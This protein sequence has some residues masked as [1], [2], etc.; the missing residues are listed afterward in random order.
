VLSHGHY[1]HTGGLNQVLPQT[2]QARIFAHPAALEHK[3]GR[4]SDGSVH[5][6]GMAG[7]NREWFQR[8]E[9]DVVW[10]DEP[11]E[12]L[13]G[14]R[15]T[16]PIPKTTTFEEDEEWMFLDEACTK[17]DPVPDDQA[18]FLESPS[19]TIVLLGCAHAGVVN[20]LRYVRQLTQDRPIHTVLGGMHLV[21]A[22]AE[23]LTATLQ[24]L[25][26]LK[27]QQFGPVHCTGSQAA[28]RLIDTFPNQCLPCHVGD[29]WE[30]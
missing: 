23:R 4:A 21:S 14:L 18:L 3:Y 26:D 15:V 1:D 27:V 9:V 8:R 22:N 28:A 16:G 24:A 12:I 17:P 11:K 2:D 25:Q 5:Y 7:I 6:I 30:F 13:G 29:R 19:G 10:T 20:T